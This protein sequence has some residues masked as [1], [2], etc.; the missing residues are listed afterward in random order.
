LTPVSTFRK[1]LIQFTGITLFIL[2]SA[3]VM[4]L[5]QGKNQ[6]DVSD[7][8]ASH[9]QIIVTSVKIEEELANMQLHLIQEAY[10]DLEPDSHGLDLYGGRYNL[11]IS[12]HTLQ[13]LFNR[14]NELQE[15]AGSI[16]SVSRKLESQFNS[17]LSS[18]LE[19][20]PGESDAVDR[21]RIQLQSL[22]QSVDQLEK[23]HS[24]KHKEL[25]RVLAT[26]SSRDN[27]N[28]V[29]FLVALALLSYL[30]IQWA[31]VSVNRS[32]DQQQ[33]SERELL[34]SQ[35]QMKNLLTALPDSVLRLNSNGEILES[36]GRQTILASADNNIVGK[37]LAEMPIPVEVQQGL[38]HG[39]QTELSNSQVYL[40]EYDLPDHD[41]TYEARI[42]KFS[43]DEVIC[44]VRD[45]TAQEV[46]RREQEK[47]TAELES[48]NAELER[49]VYTV[50]H[51]LKT[52]LVTINGYIGLLQQA[53]DANDVERINSDLMQITRAA[54]SMAEL[55]DGLLE[56]SPIR[57]IIN[58][59][60]AG[61]LDYLVRNAVD[62]VREKMIARGIELDIDD[63]MPQYWGDSLR[64]LEV[65]QNLLENAIKFMG[66]QPAP[67]IKISAVQNDNEVIC[68]VEDN[69]IGID[70]RY[71]DRIFNL[72]ERL[73]PEIEG[74]GIG[75]SLVHRIIKAHGGTISVE[76]AGEQQGCTIVFSLPVKPE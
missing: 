41:Q 44:I 68:K 75:M 30:L 19:V 10:A 9:Q 51:D 63:D 31:L 35:Q 37:T 33:L 2:A 64:L 67:R 60:E 70:P 76:S 16:D 72:F 54:N 59:P 18:P 42:I 8:A 23:F 20:E 45:V 56:L 21:A 24:L 34:Y 27:R 74:T 52:P 1:Q 49:F 43:D 50:S 6:R 14:L 61:S 57:H 69:G 32:L 39:I 62:I 73:N 25:T 12:R 3:I 15:K 47:L 40:Y 28:L 29:F 17:L 11:A 26:L 66:D 5:W 4:V 13:S 55:L 58:P 65:F 22:T 7:M 71:H 36:R 48:K 38:M 46:I 53:I